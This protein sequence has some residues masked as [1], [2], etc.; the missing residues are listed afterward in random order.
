MYLSNL[1]TLSAAAKANPP[2]NRKIVGLAKCCS[3]GL[4]S[5]NPRM[6][7]RIGIAMAVMVIGITSVSHR[8]ATKTSSA[9]P[10]LVLA[11]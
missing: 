8:I 3:A 9:R 2:K 11:S 4:V 5:T 6:T 10:L 1:L 7:E